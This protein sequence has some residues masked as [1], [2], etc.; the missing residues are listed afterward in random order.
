MWGS[1]CN[2][3]GNESNMNS[4][5]SRKD[6]Y[7]IFDSTKAKS[8]VTGFCGF[9]IENVIATYEMMWVNTSK[10]LTK[11]NDSSLGCGFRIGMETKSFAPGIKALSKDHEAILFP[12]KA[13]RYISRLN[14]IEEI[15]F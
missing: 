15:L 9:N 14:H 5:K 1:N 6:L 4:F 8:F 2:K 10:L 12:V 13:L 7:R 11:S 3:I